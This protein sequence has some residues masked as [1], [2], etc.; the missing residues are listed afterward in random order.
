[1]CPYGMHHKFNYDSLNISLLLLCVLLNRY[2]NPDT[3]TLDFVF[4]KFSQQ[5]FGSS[6][7]MKYLLTKH[8]C[9]NCFK[10]SRVVQD[11]PEVN[12]FHEAF[13]KTGI[14]CWII[15]R[16]IICK[17]TGVC[18]GYKYLKSNSML[19]LCFGKWCRKADFVALCNLQ[20]SYAFINCGLL[21]PKAYIKLK[22]I[23]KTLKNRF[24]KVKQIARM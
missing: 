18:F 12:T 23:V 10:I 13:L 5:I 20:I 15:Q 2:S 4:V 9:F 24:G 1:M 8:F 16:E 14:V 3:F 7:V 11:Y 22:T 17:S 19:F 6:V 21:F